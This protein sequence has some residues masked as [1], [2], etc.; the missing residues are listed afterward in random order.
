MKMRLNAILTKE[1]MKQMR[2]MQQE[3]RKGKDG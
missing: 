3:M 2:E 1:Q